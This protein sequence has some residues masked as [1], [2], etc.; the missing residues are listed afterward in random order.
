ME[1]YHDDQFIVFVRHDRSR[2][3]R[4]EVLERPFKR[5]ATYE[6]AR[7]VQRQLLQSA[8]NSIIRFVGQA[9]GGD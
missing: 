5:C 7:R 6:E 4:H 1:P 2:G 8:R 9:G 3:G